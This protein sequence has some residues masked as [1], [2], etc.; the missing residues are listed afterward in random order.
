MHPSLPRPTLPA[1]P[2]GLLILLTILI[3][4]LGGCT[5]ADRGWTM[6]P[7]NWEGQLPDL[8]TQPNPTFVPIVWESLGFQTP[9]SWIKSTPDQRDRLRTIAVADTKSGILYLPAAA[10]NCHARLKNN[11]DL[12]ST[13]TSVTPPQE[14]LAASDS[15]LTL[16]YVPLPITDQI[17]PV[18]GV[19]IL[20]PRTDK[21]P[22]DAWYHVRPAGSPPPYRGG[23]PF[24]QR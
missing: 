5:M 24:N 17:S 23:L 1:T 2:A 21:Q 10:A 20:N 8:T 18:C 15:K 7:V 19:R 4:S 22:S 14:I 16:W 12:A 6:P 9:A 3:L 13:S 11:A